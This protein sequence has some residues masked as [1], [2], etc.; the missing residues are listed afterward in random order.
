[1]ES[2]RLHPVAAQRAGRKGTTEVIATVEGRPLVNLDLMRWHL[3]A[4][5][6][7]LGDL[8]ARRPCLRVPVQQPLPL[9][10]GRVAVARARAHGAHQHCRLRLHRQRV[11]R[12]HAVRDPA[13]HAA[14]DPLRPPRLAH[15]RRLAAGPRAHHRRPACRLR[16]GDRVGRD[17]DVRRSARAGRPRAAGRQPVGADLPHARNR[18]CT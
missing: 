18:A 13:A 8:P 10:G 2:R 16:A 17:A 7:S 15:L 14:P 1:M 4:S 11:H 9:R 6:A 5:A 3:I 12:R